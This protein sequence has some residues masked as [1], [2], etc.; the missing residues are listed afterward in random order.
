MEKQPVFEGISPREVYDLGEYGEE[1]VKGLSDRDIQRLVK[2][3][4]RRMRRH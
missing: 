4:L 3:S 2:K 1:P